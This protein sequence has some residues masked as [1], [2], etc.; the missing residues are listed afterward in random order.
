MIKFG[1]DLWRSRYL[2]SR[3]P[4]T[5]FKWFLKMSKEGG[6]STA[7]LG[8]IFQCSHGKAKCMGFMSFTFV[9]QEITCLI[10]D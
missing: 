9:G 8:N 4:R 10:P 5:M 1:R 3:L 6:V 2:E 7:F